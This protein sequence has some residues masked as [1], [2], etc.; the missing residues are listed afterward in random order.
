MQMAK[1]LGLSLASKFLGLDELCDLLD[2]FCVTKPIMRDWA[3]N[4]DLVWSTLNCYFTHIQRRKIP[5]PCLTRASVLRIA[6]SV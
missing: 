2:R 6:A 4:S 3:E 5:Q 1:I